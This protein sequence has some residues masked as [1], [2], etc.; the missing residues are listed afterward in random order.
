MKL[1]PDEQECTTCRDALS[2]ALSHR[3]SESSILFSPASTTRSS[4]S[5]VRW[6][7][8]LA[9]SDRETCPQYILD[10]GVP[11]YEA[12]Y[13]W[14]ASPATEYREHALQLMKYLLET[15][16]CIDRNAIGFKQYRIV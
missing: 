4:Q 12:V 8:L 15:R 11:S 14:L 6:V 1:V 16:G 10:A 7:L 3:L 2:A 13:L 5:C 9:P